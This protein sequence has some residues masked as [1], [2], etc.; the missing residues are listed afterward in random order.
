MRDFLIYKIYM[1]LFEV[2]R[3]LLIII[4]ATFI[5]VA[6][7]GVVANLITAVIAFSVAI[8]AAIS[9]QIYMT[10]IKGKIG[11][12]VTQK[13]VE[14]YCD[15]RGYSYLYD[16]MINND[17]DEI[18]QID[19]LVITRR[20][21]AVIETKFNTGVVSGSENDS[22]WINVSKKHNTVVHNSNYDNPLTKNHATVEVLKKIIDREVEYYNIVVFMDKVN[23]KG[24]EVVNKFTKVGF[25]YD[26]NII[27]EELDTLSDKKITSVEAYEIYNKIKVANITNNELK[28]EYIN[29]MNKT[30]V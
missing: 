1:I 6:L 13:I 18:S 2:L 7:P 21:I 9:S 10:K 5:I 17:K 19:H 16:V 24:C 26:L 28:Q 23:F 8:L 15:K 25:A 22:I 3:G 4:L 27:I 20:G 14:S 29:K 12:Y 11:E 30:N